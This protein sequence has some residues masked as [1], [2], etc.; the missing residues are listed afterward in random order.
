M[1]AAPRGETLDPI[2]YEVLRH[3]LWAIN[4]EQ[5]L[6]AAQM[7]GSPVVY[8]AYDFNSALMSY[9]GDTL[10]IGVYVT[11]L[12]LSIDIAVKNIVKDYSRDPGIHEGD[13][14]L[15]NDPWVGAVHMNDYIVVA[16]IHHEGRVVC[17]TGL[18]MHEMDVGGPVPGSFVVGA[19]DIY[20]E[21]PVLPPLKVVEAGR[22]RPDVERMF[23]RNS[24][25]PEFN[26]LDL[27]A[28]IA[29][30]NKTRQRIAEIIET[31]GVDTFLAVQ[32]RLLEDVRRR[33]G[34]R[35]AELPDGAWY[36][37]GYIDHDGSTDALY[38]IKVAMTKRG[39]RLT[40]DFR[41]T[42]PQAPGMINC[43]Y[44]GLWGGVMAAMLTLLC[45]DMPWATGA[46]S[47]LVE[48]IS[49]EGT[50]NNAR[51]PAAVSAATVA[52]TFMTFNVC[53]QAIAKMYACSER[54][55]GELMA[56]GWPGWIGANFS[57][58]DQ[59]GRY[60]TA[61]MLDTGGGGGARSTRDGLDVEGTPGSPKMAMSN[62]ETVER[63]YPLLYLYRKE[64]PATLGPGKYRGGAG[65]ELGR[66]VHKA[67]SPVRCFV[68]GHGINQS[69]ARGL[70]GGLPG[71]VNANVVY[72]RA[73]Q[74]QGAPAAGRSL[75]GGSEE[76][77]AVEGAVLAAKDMT[78][79][80]N[81]DAIVTYCC[82]GGGY[83]DPLERE[84]HLV[85]ADAA[86]GLCDVQSAVRLYGVVLD[87]QSL[88]PDLLATAKTRDAVRRG[89][90]GTSLAV[91]GWSVGAAGGA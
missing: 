1:Q 44:T 65:L 5:G 45:Y 37:H 55:R 69:E 30:I 90:R 71:S 7:S 63:L 60:F 47:G 82:G 38:E 25:T 35:L 51:H 6:L 79:L 54:Y 57:G 16:P 84:P 41:G 31:Y 64:Q 86:Q 43:T 4:D 80:E 2:T 9:R 74:P 34:R 24:R 23:I 87:P 39:E 62:I 89:R 3:R 18:C 10:F 50:V 46:I 83:G 8:E 36:E 48:I 19:R 73:W 11:R 91:E 67:A 75:P 56:T 52:A 68:F 72:R 28:R 33:L 17:W 88:A 59:R 27:R 49:E 21:A 81:G 85:S 32:E 61:T 77:G 14:F 66:L 70:M 26:A 58:L 78:M 20:G 76:M 15:T 12:S 13:M 40:F 22:L 53:M 42:S 29:A